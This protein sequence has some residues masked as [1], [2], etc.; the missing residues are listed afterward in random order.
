MICV[1]KLPPA[2]LQYGYTINSIIKRS[3]TN[4]Q[5]NIRLKMTRMQKPITHNSIEINKHTSTES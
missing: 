1:A 3:K 4:A 5:T 2:T